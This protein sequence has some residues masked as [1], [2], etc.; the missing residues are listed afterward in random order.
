[1]APARECPNCGAS[2]EEDARFC[3]R[4]GA[5]LGDSD[6]RRQAL[7]AGQELCEIG[8]WRGYLRSEFFAFAVGEP[9]DEPLPRSEPFRWREEDPPPRLDPYLEVYQALVEK[10]TDAGWT[11]AGEGAEWFS[12]RFT[13]ARRDLEDE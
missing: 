5:P 3:S 10:L 11:R 7:E 8:F 2:A 12:A 1:M 6:L 13:R 4:C 9:S